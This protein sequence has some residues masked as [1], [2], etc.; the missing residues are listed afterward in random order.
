LKGII[1]KCNSTAQSKDDNI[2]IYTQRREQGRQAR[3]E[4]SLSIVSS[5]I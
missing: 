5:I 3:D 2:G 1:A 4:Y